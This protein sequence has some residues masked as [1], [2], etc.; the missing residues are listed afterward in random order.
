MRITDQR[1]MPITPEPR[2][3]GLVLHGDYIYEIKAC[4][5][6]KVNLRRKNTHPDP[7]PPPPYLRMRSEKW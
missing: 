4:D 7:A 1:P 5:G 2:H 6:K 3:R